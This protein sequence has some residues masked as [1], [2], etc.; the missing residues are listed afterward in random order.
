MILVLL[1]LAVE[2]FALTDSQ[3][4]RYIG[5]RLAKTNSECLESGFCSSIVKLEQS[6]EITS[7]FFHASTTIASSIPCSEAQGYAYVVR[8]RESSETVHACDSLGPLFERILLKGLNHLR[9]TNERL[10]TN[11]IKDMREFIACLNEAGD[12]ASEISALV[13][14]FEKIMIRLLRQSISSPHALDSQTGIFAPAFH[15]FFDVVAVLQEVKMP[16][17]E[18][19][20]PITLQTYMFPALYRGRYLR[21]AHM[22]LPP[23]TDAER[24]KAVAAAIDNL[25]LAANRRADLLQSGID[26]INFFLATPR[27]APSATATML[28]YIL[29]SA[30]CPNLVSVSEFLESHPG[31]KR[32]TAVKLGVTLI[33]IC[34]E[35]STLIQ[36]EQASRAL[37]R[38]LTGTPRESR[39]DLTFT[40]EDPVFIITDSRRPWI[41]ELDHDTSDDSA[42]ILRDHFFFFSKMNLRE[43][44]DQYV[45]EHTMFIPKAEFDERMDYSE[46]TR[47]L[48]RVMGLCLRDRARMDNL[49][50]HPIIVKLLYSPLQKLEL[51]LIDFDA[52]V[53]DIPHWITLGE[54]LESLAYV[55]EG[56]QD[57][58]GPGGLVAFTL[59]EFEAMFFD[60]P[61]VSQS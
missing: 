4:C 15:F 1:V 12:A 28:D 34:S 58:L 24:A 11:V 27:L 49:K 32:T 61:L 35:N 31:V 38:L 8:T 57:V 25:A 2:A 33:S 40:I 36:R 21:E 6:G 5:A 7:G 43:V 17:A 9:V 48:G 53:F 42:L 41:S 19:L 54:I 39:L 3:A 59:L 60:F 56:I 29:K 13:P 14:K 52:P 37:G 23:P 47:G 10:G 45:W 22:Q 46:F 20:L 16:T 55:R 18:A 30:L 51:E 26:T 50:L 44:V